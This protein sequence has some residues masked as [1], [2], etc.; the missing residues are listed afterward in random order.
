MG[1]SFGW[2]G[3]VRD[4]VACSWSSEVLYATSIFVAVRKELSTKSPF[5][6]GTLVQTMSDKDENVFTLCVHWYGTRRQTCWMS[7]AYYPSFQISDAKEF[8]RI[9]WNKIIGTDTN[10]LS[11]ERLKKDKKLFAMVQKLLQREGGINSVH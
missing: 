8:I 2:Q 7:D 11:F 6:I 9:P 3:K 5:W 4:E 10:I 1:Y